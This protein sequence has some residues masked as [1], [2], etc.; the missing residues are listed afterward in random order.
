MEAQLWIGEERYAMRGEGSIALESIPAKLALILGT[1]AERPLSFSLEQNY[2][3]PF[4]PLT[5]I[6]YALPRASHVT[7]NVCNMLG[8]EV[9]TLV[10]EQQESGYRSVQWNATG[11]ATGV[12]F[13]RL[14]TQPMEGGQAGSFVQTRK[15]VIIK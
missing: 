12:Y 15:M 14:K 3:N 11:L 10:N 5:T 2:P 6:R 13:L 9:V 7:L 1:G 4:N 8:Q